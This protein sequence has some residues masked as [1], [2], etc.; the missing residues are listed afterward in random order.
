MRRTTWISDDKCAVVLP[1][2]GDEE[3]IEMRQPSRPSPAFV[4]QHGTEAVAFFDGSITLF[5]VLELQTIF[6][7]CSDQI[8]AEFIVT[9]AMLIARAEP[10]RDREIAWTD[11]ESQEL[12]PVTSILCYQVAGS[13]SPV[14]VADD[15][16]PPDLDK[17]I[18]AIVTVLAS[19]AS[20]ISALCKLRVCRIQKI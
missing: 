14:S 13:V 9:Q 2:V 5:V 17:V 18:L 10:P 7:G 20:G 1:R 16:M 19:R 12:S 8:A 15:A 3:L 11:F 6:V 4:L